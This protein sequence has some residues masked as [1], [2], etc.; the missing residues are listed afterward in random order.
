MVPSCLTDYFKLRRTLRTTP[1]IASKTLVLQFQRPELDQQLRFMVYLYKNV[2]VGVE[3]GEILWLFVTLYMYLEMAFA[4]KLLNMDFGFGAT[5]FL[6]P[7]VEA[8]GWDIRYVAHARV[9]EI[10][11][12]PAIASVQTSH[13]VL[14]PKCLSPSS[15]EG[16]PGSSSTARQYS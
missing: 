6:V 3:H 8:E 14:F 7:N 9:W 1:T 4:I 10:G 16:T 12:L 13:R 11:N 2:S 15:C 5:D